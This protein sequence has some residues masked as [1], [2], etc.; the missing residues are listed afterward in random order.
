MRK[1]KRFRS[2]RWTWHRDKSTL[3]IWDEPENQGREIGSNVEFSNKDLEEMIKEKGTM[4]WDNP[5]YYE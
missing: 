4:V 3:F 2:R 5:V 1:S